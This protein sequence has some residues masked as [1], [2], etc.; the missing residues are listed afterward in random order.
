MSNHDELSIKDFYIKHLGFCVG[1]FKHLPIFQITTLAQVAHA[2]H[3]KQ[4]ICFFLRYRVKTIKAGIPAETG[5]CIYAAC[6]KNQ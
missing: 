5:I 2:S 4:N 1:C 6:A 3:V